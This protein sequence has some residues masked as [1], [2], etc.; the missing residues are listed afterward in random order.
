MI[1]S[2][3][4]NQFPSSFA[5]L[6]NLFKT[7]MFLSNLNGFNSSPSLPD[8]GF[9]TRKGS[10]KVQKENGSKWFSHFSL[11]LFLIALLVCLTLLFWVS[12][13]LCIA[14]SCLTCFV[15]LFFSF[16]SFCFSYK[17]KKKNEKLEKYKNSVCMCTLVLVYLGWPLK[18]S[19]LN[20]VS[21]VAKMST[22][23]HN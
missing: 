3:D 17:N 11:S 23:M 10:S 12:L 1:A 9:A 5:P 18:Q 20:F 7:L 4:Q 15:W 22:S 16:A 2:G 19:F 6:G 13:V 8:Q 21:F 14:L